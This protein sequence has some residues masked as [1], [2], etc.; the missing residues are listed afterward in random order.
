MEKID[1]NA[2]SRSE[3]LLGE[4]GMRRL[5]DCTVMVFG[6]GGVGSHLTD[7]L[8]RGGIGR[9]IL[10]DADTVSVTNINRQSVAFLSTVGQY[11]TD[12]MRKRIA[13]ICPDT[14]VL[15]YETFVLPENI[16]SLMES[17]PGT[18]D[19]VADAI[20]TISAKLALAE[21][22]TAH[23][24]PLISCM[25]TGNKLH[26]EMFE[27][28]DISNTSVCPVCKVMRRELKKRGISRLQ[29]LYSK[30]PPMTPLSGEEFRNP[31]S[32]HRR[33]VPGSVSFV[34]PVAGLFIA[35]EILRTLC[36]HTDLTQK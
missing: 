25:G 30:E 16:G 28:T 2:F 21:Y 15:T 3:L 20:D 22:C 36:A 6:I 31:E 29:V 23:R 19:Y 10:V 4:D 27:I 17:I 33:P 24:I 32:K 34:P 5:A 12:I 7:A 26:P 1:M 11:K 9:L 18:I 35:G 8:A 14:E 13:D